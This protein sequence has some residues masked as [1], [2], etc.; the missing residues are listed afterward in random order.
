MASVYEALTQIHSLLGQRIG[1]GQCYALTALYEHYITPDSTVGLGAGVNGITGLKKGGLNASDIGEDFNWEQ[2]GWEVK[3]NV[4]NADEI[5]VGAIINWHKGGIH[6]N[7][8]YPVNGTYGHT[9]VVYAKQ[10]AT[11]FVFEQNHGSETIRQFSGSNLSGISSVVIP[12]EL[13]K[14]SVSAPTTTNKPAIKKGELVLDVA[15]YQPADLRQLTSS[16]G[17]SKTIIKATEGTTYVNPYL[18]GQVNTSSPVGFYHFARFGGD[19]AAA[20]AEATFF[21]SRIPSGHAG[22]IAVCDY[23]SGASPDVSANTNA[24]LVFMRHLK[25]AGYFPVIYS[26]TSYLGNFDLD[27]IL[28]EFPGSFWEAWY[29]VL[30]PIH[31]VETEYIPR[32]SGKG[33]LWQ[34]SSDW[35]GLNVDVSVALA[36]FGTVAQGPVEEDLEEEELNKFNNIVVRTTSGKQGYWAITNGKRW[37]VSSIDTV[38]ALKGLGYAEISIADADFDKFLSKFDAK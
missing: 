28:R 34:F 14:K 24:I 22:T 25:A 23:E 9:G 2:N 35:K 36:D 10:G 11:L 4:R 8:Q 32:L 20:K 26:Y 1:N 13:A 31:R 6:I 5:P 29:S 12:P 38:N 16:A 27:A 7:G 3:Y 30:T 37:G 17:T 18:N 15:S 33:G 19:V 21:Q